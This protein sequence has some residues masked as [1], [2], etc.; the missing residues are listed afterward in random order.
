MKQ[1]LNKF[2]HFSLPNIPTKGYNTVH[3][4]NR[5][6]N[7]TFSEER[8]LVLGWALGRDDWTIVMC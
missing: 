2:T 8:S 5:I 6:Y 1:Y 4:I 3:Y 7:G